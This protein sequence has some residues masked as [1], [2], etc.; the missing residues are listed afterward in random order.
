MKMS[1]L[2][3]FSLSAL[4]CAAALLAP[5]GA[6]QAGVFD[7]SGQAP[8]DAASYQAGGDLDWIT[9]TRASSVSNSGANFGWIDAFGSSSVLQQAGRVEYYTGNDNSSLQL[10]GGGINWLALTG[11]ASAELRGGDISWLHRSGNAHLT[12]YGQNLRYDGQLLSGL[13]ADGTRFSFSL[14][15]GTAEDSFAVN[16]NYVTL[17]NLA[18]VPEP[19]TYALLA[20]GLG[21]VSM[22]AKR[23][24][25]AQAA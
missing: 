22:V 8:V 4:A 7:A 2:K 1:R 5:L 23:R 19:E 17:V 15:D 13:W 12:V 24:R 18:P 9:V 3:S 16:L 20:L 11:D 21:V 10:L 14:L 25:A 6:A